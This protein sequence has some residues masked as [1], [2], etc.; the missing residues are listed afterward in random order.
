MGLAAQPSGVGKGA[1]ADLART[2]AEFAGVHLGITD[3]TARVH[4]RNLRA[5][6]ALAKISATLRAI[7][8]HTML[9]SSNVA[10]MGDIR[11]LTRRSPLPGS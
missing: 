1:F 4:V 6:G 2:L 10:T 3:L 7:D 11:L 8:G 9:W 5:A